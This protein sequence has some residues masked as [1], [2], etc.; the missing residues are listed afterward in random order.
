MVSVLT[1]R[2]GERD[3]PS[4]ICGCVSLHFSERHGKLGFGNHSTLGRVDIVFHT[5]G[6]AETAPERPRGRVGDVILR[7]WAQTLYYGCHSLMT[8]DLGGYGAGPIYQKNDRR[9]VESFV[10]WGVG[11][12]EASQLTTREDQ[13]TAIYPTG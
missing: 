3:T 9:L 12:L 8:P 11:N 6:M 4:L 2:T 13:R 5:V 1:A 10:F 7:K